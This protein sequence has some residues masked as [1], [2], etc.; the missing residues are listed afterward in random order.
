MP[1]IMS[2]GYGPGI[3]FARFSVVHVWF[4]NW[5]DVCRLAKNPGAAC[6]LGDHNVD[7]LSR[8]NNDLF[9][10]FSRDQILNALIG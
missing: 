10:R 3:S 8:D 4:D 2:I 7:E 9:D 5:G 1:D 6:R